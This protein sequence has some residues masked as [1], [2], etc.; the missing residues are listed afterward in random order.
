MGEVA[1]VAWAGGGGVGLGWCGGWLRSGGEAGGWVVD[2]V[3]C[4][5]GGCGVAEWIAAEGRRYLVGLTPIRSEIPARRGHFEIFGPN[6]SI[7]LRKIVFLTSLKKRLR[8]SIFQRSKKD[9]KYYVF[10]II[11]PKARNFLDIIYP[12]YSRPKGGK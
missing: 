12:P 5:G 9:Y 7:S 1:G 10:K 2:W 11:A 6:P 3:G 4:G 8:R